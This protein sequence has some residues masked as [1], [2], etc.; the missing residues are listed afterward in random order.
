MASHEAGATLPLAVD[1]LRSRVDVQREGWY[2][3]FGWLS[4]IPFCDVCL[5]TVGRMYV[6]CIPH[7]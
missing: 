3:T 7:L 5:C 2:W 1:G 6:Y 4:D